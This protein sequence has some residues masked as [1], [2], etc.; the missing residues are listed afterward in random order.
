MHVVWI[1]INVMLFFRKLENQLESTQKEL[2]DTKLNNAKLTTQLD[3]SVE[4]SKVLEKNVTA[5]KQEIVALRTKAEQYSNLVA[6]V[7]ITVNVVHHIH[8]LMP[9][10]F[11]HI[12]NFTLCLLHVHMTGT[13]IYQRVVLEVHT[14][15]WLLSDNDPNFTRQSLNKV[16][17]S[18]SHLRHFCS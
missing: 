14:K 6:K 18:Q 16:F 13:C 12:D 2:T 3:Y 11:A 4:S 17:K 7:S 5:Y 10:A 8:Q 15:D 1:H 9:A